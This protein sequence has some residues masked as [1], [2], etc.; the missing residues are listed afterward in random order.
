[1]R[2]VAAVA[3]RGSLAGWA[4]VTMSEEILSQWEK[5]FR[6]AA[7]ADELAIFRDHLR[8]LDL[9]DNPHIMLEGTIRLVRM[10]AGYAMMDNRNEQFGEF[11]AMQTYDPAKATEAHYVYT[12]DICGKA[13]ARVLVEAKE[14][15]VDLSDMYGS[16]WNDYKVVGFHHLW[17]SH[18]DWSPL[19]KEEVTE[20]ESII[21]SDLRFDYT[22]DEVAF[23]CD[24]TLDETYLF[25]TVQDVYDDE[26]DA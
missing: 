26:R 12:F 2:L 17:V 5:D 7:F 22:A 16:L 1:M 9:P 20:I 10:C 18:P 21:T 8:R 19:P 14:G 23:W 24:D 25:V 13:F 3:E 11:L 15:I 4:I 6:T